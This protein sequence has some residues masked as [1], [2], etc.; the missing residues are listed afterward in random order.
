MEGGL[1][2]KAWTNFRRDSTVRW[3][4]DTVSRNSERVPGEAIR[5]MEGGNAVK[6]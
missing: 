3:S 6:T 1:S 2:N 4:G 5:K